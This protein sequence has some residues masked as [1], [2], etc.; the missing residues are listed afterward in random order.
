M[1]TEGNG[2][3][4]GLVDDALCLAVQVSKGHTYGHAETPLSL[5]V[6]AAASICARV[7]DDEEVIT[8]VL[9]DAMPR[10]PRPSMCDAAQLFGPSVL[11]LLADLSGLHLQDTPSECWRSSVQM[12][13]EILHRPRDYRTREAC[14][15]AL[16]VEAYDLMA[17]LY[18]AREKAWPWHGKADPETQLWRHEQYLET[19]RPR[20]KQLRAF[21]EY[22]DIVLRGIPL[23]VPGRLPHF[24]DNPDYDMF[25]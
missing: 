7:T 23:Y 15:G 9:L 20:M 13:L 8:A 14:L 21:R 5:H 17:D 4:T 1:N 10:P 22:D 3:K 16:L 2:T 12:H 19:L 25:E 18:E 11:A 24:Y 6:A